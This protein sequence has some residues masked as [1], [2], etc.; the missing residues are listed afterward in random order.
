MMV[1]ARA[2]VAAM[3]RWSEG[4]AE[5][6]ERVAHRF[7]RVEGRWQRIAAALGVEEAL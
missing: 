2:E 3:E 7:Q 5:V 4:L 1:N 6:H